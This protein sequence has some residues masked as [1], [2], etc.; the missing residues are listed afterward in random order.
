MKGGPTLSIAMAARNAEAFMGA[1]LESIAR[2]LGPSGIDHE[3]LVA[4]GT[5][6]DRTREIASQS[7]HARIVSLS[8]DG[9]YDGMNR[10]I[11]A[12]QGEAVVILNADD[13]LM[14]GLPDAVRTLHDAPALVSVTGSVT[15][16]SI[17]ASATPLVP[18]GRMTPESI[19]F[20]IPALNG[21]VFR[22]EALASLGPI[23]TNI[24]LGADRAYLMHLAALGPRAVVSRASLYFY[25][26]HE[27]SR[28]IAGDPAAR[29]RIYLSDRELAAHL[30]ALGTP[31]APC[32]DVAAFEAIVRMKMLRLGR[33]GRAR[34]ALPRAPGGG[35]AGL[36]ALIRGLNA[37]RRWRGRHS[38]W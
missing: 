11:G 32:E 3:I 28:T 22:R 17:P 26:V 1:A 14:P 2:V 7:A 36:P 30:A 12:A 33:E 6:S 16:G 29:R 9:L 13:E 37:W 20:G 5:S 35:G 19:L 21:R 8:D 27:G 25:R 15:V 34:D 4:D 18:S 10:A 23:R 24:G 31:A 38:G